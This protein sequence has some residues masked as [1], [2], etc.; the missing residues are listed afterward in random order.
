MSRFNYLLFIALVMTVSLVSFG[1]GARAQTA[2]APMVPAARTAVPRRRVAH[3]NTQRTEVGLGYLNYN[4]DIAI[5]DGTNTS[6]GVASY[7]GIA[8]IAEHSWG[9]GR[10][11]LGVHGSFASGKA[12]ANISGAVAFPDGTNRAWSAIQLEP[13]ARYAFNEYVYFGFGL[14]YRHT[15]ITWASADSTLTVQPSKKSA[16]APQFDFRIQLTRRWTIGQSYAPLGFRALT[17]ATY[18]F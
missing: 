14:L 18:A 9:F 17:Y 5:T 1:S 11:R 7:G 3:R 15:S 2:N 10:L 8:F 13:F 6:K 16:I 12:A 4:E